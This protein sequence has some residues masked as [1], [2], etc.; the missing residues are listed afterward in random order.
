MSVEERGAFFVELTAGAEEGEVG[1]EG[2]VGV[3]FIAELAGK[4]EE[5]EGCFRR[6]WHGCNVFVHLSG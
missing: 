5:G 2:G 1:R 4:I 3:D 6:W